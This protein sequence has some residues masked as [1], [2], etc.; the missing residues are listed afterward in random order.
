MPNISDIQIYV[1]PVSDKHNSRTSAGFHYE[2]YGEIS[3]S[4]TH[5]VDFHY[6]TYGEISPSRTH[7]VDFHYETYGEISPSHTILYAS[8]LSLIL[9][10]QVDIRTR[11]YMLKIKICIVI[12]I[13]YA[14]LGKMG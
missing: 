2:T 11:K 4:R 1:N 13:K 3:P 9:P 12:I 10:F 8:L 7:A 5:A 6:E 14:S